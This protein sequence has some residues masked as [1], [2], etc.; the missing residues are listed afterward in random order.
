M[1]GCIKEPILLY[2]TKKRSF[3]TV[4]FFYKGMMELPIKEMKDRGKERERPD[5][6]YCCCPAQQGIL[7]ARA[8]TV[9]AAK[10]SRYSPAVSP[11]PSPSLPFQYGGEACGRGTEHE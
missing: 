4:I 5:T 3:L 7:S 10:S 11:A 6:Q 1:A 9:L 2:F 8:T